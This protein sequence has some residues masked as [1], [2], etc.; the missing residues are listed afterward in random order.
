MILAQIAEA[1][2]K[3]LPTPDQMAGWSAT[4]FI[5]VLFGLLLCGISVVGVWF[6]RTMNQNTKDLNTQNDVM[7]RELVARYDRQDERYDKQ[8]LRHRERDDKTN[9]TMRAGLEKIAE[10]IRTMR[11]SH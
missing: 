5:Q 10:S 7:F 4:Q 3:I 11:G 1:T 9:E 2:S 8:E 6:V